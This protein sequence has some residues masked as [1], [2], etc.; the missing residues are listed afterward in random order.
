MLAITTAAMTPT[1]I[2]PRAATTTPLLP[3]GTSA[4][5]GTSLAAIT[6]TSPAGTTGT[7]VATTGTTEGGPPLPQRGGARALPSLLVGMTFPRRLRLLRA[8]ADGTKKRMLLARVSFLR[9]F[10]FSYGENGTAKRFACLLA[11][12][13]TRS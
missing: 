13:N 1:P 11:S 12:E 7:V 2:G 6:V 9:P 8:R 4:T 5:T 3:V 10:F